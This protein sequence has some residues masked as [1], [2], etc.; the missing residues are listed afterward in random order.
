VGLYLDILA[1]FADQR[2]E[3]VPDAIMSLCN[4]TPFLHDRAWLTVLLTGIMKIETH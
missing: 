2:R 4:K 3:K 1:N